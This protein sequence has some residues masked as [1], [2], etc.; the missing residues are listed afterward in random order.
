MSQDASMKTPARDVT[1]AILAGGEG[2]RMGKPK[3]LLT[4]R[5][6]P[7]LSYLLR[8]ISWPG[9][10]MLVTAPGREHPPGWQAFGREVTDPQAAGPLRGV[11]TALEHLQT[12]LLVVLTVDMPFIG[13]EHIRWLLARFEEHSE[14]AGLMMRRAA[15]AGRQIEPFPS[16]YRDIALPFIRQSLEKNRRSVH[17]LLDGSLFLAVDVPAEWEARAWTNLNQPADLQRIQDF[18]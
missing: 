5:G 16:A 14:H 12:P 7:I 2:S 3:G 13:V 9:P 17:G 8:R 18:R 10:T 4:I 6:E 15:S 1:L 11:L